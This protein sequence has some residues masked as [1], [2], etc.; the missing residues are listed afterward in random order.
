[1]VATVVTTEQPR[2]GAHDVRQR[3]RTD[4]A[5]RLLENLAHV[6]GERDHRVAVR[7][8]RVEL[9]RLRG[10]LEHGVPVPPGDGEAAGAGLVE[11]GQ[12]DLVGS[13]GEHDLREPG[14]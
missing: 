14:A 13:G 4:D 6:H 7:T 1:M 3:E 2:Y 11:A 10:D 5:L 9:K 12:D 8:L